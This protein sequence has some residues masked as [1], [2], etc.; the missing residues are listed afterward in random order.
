[1]V[2][3]AFLAR[4]QTKNVSARSLVQ[5]SGAPAWLRA[6]ARDSRRSQLS[7]PVPLPGRMRITKIDIDDPP[8]GREQGAL[9]EAD[10]PLVAL[11]SGDGIAIG[12]DI[13]GPEHVDSS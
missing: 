7:A 9:V 5:D 8:A 4:S 2:A 6:P 13:T 11:R 1:M 12:D 3:A 10:Q